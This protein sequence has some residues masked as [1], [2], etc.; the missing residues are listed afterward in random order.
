M[1]F[2]LD[3][4]HHDG[5]RSRACLVPAAATTHI[6]QQTQRYSGYRNR[7]TA[8]IA[9]RCPDQ[10]SDCRGVRAVAVLTRRRRPP[11]LDAA[12][13]ALIPLRPLTITE[14]LDRGFLIVRRNI[15]LMIG[16]TWWWP[17]APPHTSWPGSAC[18]C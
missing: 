16:L 13:T 17:A 14:I 1:R 8:P 18:G 12:R 5:G 7:L 9:A 4:G 2:L 3:A 10:M 6:G 15:R 11:A